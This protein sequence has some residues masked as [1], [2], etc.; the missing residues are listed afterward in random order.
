MLGVIGNPE[1][2]V[3]GEGLGLELSRS[4]IRVIAER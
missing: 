4:F 2:Q 3:F 1:S